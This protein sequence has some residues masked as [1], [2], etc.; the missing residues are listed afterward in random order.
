MIIFSD[1]FALRALPL[2]KGEKESIDPVVDP[3]DAR[4]RTSVCTHF[5]RAHYRVDFP[6]KFCRIKLNTLKP[7][8]HMEDID[9]RALTEGEVFTKKKSLIRKAFKVL[10]MSQTEKIPEGK[11]I[12]VS[13]KGIPLKERAEHFYF[14]EKGEYVS[15][16][17]EGGEYIYNRLRTAKKFELKTLRFFRE[18]LISL[19]GIG[20]HAE[21]LCIRHMREHYRK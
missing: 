6:G 9:K 2:S 17:P 14:N 4:L 1:P 8:K 19:A 10:L 7:N 21:M 5:T 12:V 18:S 15:L 13:Q 3:H 11:I 16:F 20:S